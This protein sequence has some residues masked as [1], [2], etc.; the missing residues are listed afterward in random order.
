MV[1]SL[2]KK[3]CFYL[4]LFKLFLLQTKPIK[5]ITIGCPIFDMINFW[6]FFSFIQNKFV[7]VSDA[8]NDASFIIDHF[9]SMYIKGILIF[10]LTFIVYPQIS[11]I[12]ECCSLY[13]TFPLLLYNLLTLLLFRAVVSLHWKI[14]SAGPSS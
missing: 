4:F 1:N 8:Q 12:L 2:R 6:N 3:K 7:L 5:Y 10:F 11:E 14:M 9:L 13:D